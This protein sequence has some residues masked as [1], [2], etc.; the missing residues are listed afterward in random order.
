MNKRQAKKKRKK[1]SLTI[2]KTKKKQLFKYS[3]GSQ[4][5]K[6]YK[7]KAKDITEKEIKWLVK[8][9]NKR[10]YNIERYGLQSHSQEYRNIKHYAISEPNASG[11]Y[12]NVNY[13][14]GTIRITSDLSRFQSR[15]ELT[16][17]INRLRNIYLTQ[18][19]TVKGTKVAMKKGYKTFL[20]TTGKSEKDISYNKYGEIWR[21]F[22]EMVSEDKKAKGDSEVIVELITHTNY[23]ELSMEELRET[24]SYINMF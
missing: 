2:S 24:M 20:E 9:L 15:S 7:K 13:E 14:K 3:I 19:S 6:V 5:H 4:G 10:L 21:T 18:T 22:R 17:F 1:Q 8:T 16:N 12:Y 11:K 23:Y